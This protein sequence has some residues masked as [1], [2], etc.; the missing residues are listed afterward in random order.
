M[1]ESVNNYCY[2]YNKFIEDKDISTYYIRNGLY[3]LQ[4]H[5]CEKEKDKIIIKS[6]SAS[7]RLTIAYY[8]W[9]NGYVYHF[10]GMSGYEYLSK[11]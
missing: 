8:H 2:Y 4:E 3:Y 9:L 7:T 1:E 6:N 11:K 10:G 5:Y